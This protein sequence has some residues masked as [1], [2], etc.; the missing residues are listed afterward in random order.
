MREHVPRTA[1]LYLPDAYPMCIDAMASR[2]LTS[3]SWARR[4]VPPVILPSSRSP[5][6]LSVPYANRLVHSL[7]SDPAPHLSHSI[8]PG[9]QV[10]QPTRPSPAACPYFIPQ[11]TAGSAFFIVSPPYHRAYTHPFRTSISN[12]CSEL[13]TYRRIVPR[14]TTFIGY[15][16][17]VCFTPSS[18]SQ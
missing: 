15:P 3:T 6:R 2:W 5:P 13:V 4:A 14:L 18:P 12:A 17:R 10:L 8:V 7:T 16:T 11:F 9:R 1:W